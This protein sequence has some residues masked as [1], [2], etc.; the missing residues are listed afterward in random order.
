MNKNEDND[1]ARIGKH[2]LFAV[3]SRVLDSNGLHERLLRLHFHVVAKELAIVGEREAL[4]LLLTRTV[5][6]AFAQVVVRR[7]FGKC[8]IRYTNTHVNNG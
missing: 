3:D 2:R 4:T 7:N 1:T 6:V 8:T 5:L